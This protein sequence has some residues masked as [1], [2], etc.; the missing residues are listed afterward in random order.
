MESVLITCARLVGMKSP[1][2][3]L[4]VTFFRFKDALTVVNRIGH[5]LAT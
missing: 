3:V 1:V 2:R 4:T 5:S